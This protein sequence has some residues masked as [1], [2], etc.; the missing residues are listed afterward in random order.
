MK[1]LIYAIII[2]SINGAA[3]L[4][5]SAE[6]GK[7]QIVFTSRI[8]VR[9]LD[10]ETF[11]PVDAQIL[12]IGSKPENYIDPI[13]E[14]KMYKYRISSRDTTSFSIYAPGYEPLTESIRVSEINGT[15]VFYLTP[16]VSDQNAATASREDRDSNWPDLRDDIQSVCISIR[17]AHTCRSARTG[18]LKCS[19]IFCREIKSARLSLQA[20]PTM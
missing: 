3:A 18:S 14:D 6:P 10:K 19:W 16:K 11:K 8:T 5:Q 1:T 15:E 9:V 2:F 13:F 4:C 7:S 17:A 20:I 12:V